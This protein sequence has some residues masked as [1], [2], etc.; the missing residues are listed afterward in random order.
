MTQISL[1]NSLTSIE[2][3]TFYGTGLKNVLLPEGLQSI[4]DSAFASSK[5]EGL[6]IPASVNY[7]DCY[8]FESNR[9]LSTVY[10]MPATPP[11]VGTDYDD[12]DRYWDAFDGCAAGCMIYVPQSSLDSYKSASYWKEYKDKMVGYSF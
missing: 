6:T 8:A 1:C 12:G 2:N 3:Y 9:N 10:C 11:S 7:I 5:L 4:G